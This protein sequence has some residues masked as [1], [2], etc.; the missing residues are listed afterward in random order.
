MLFFPRNIYHCVC[1]VAFLNVVEFAFYSF[2]IS[3]YLSF[4]YSILSSVLQVFCFQRVCKHTLFLQYWHYVAGYS[5]LRCEAGFLSCPTCRFHCHRGTTTQSMPWACRQCDVGKL[6]VRPRE[7]GHADS[8]L[9]AT[10][11]QPESCCFHHCGRP[12]L[13]SLGL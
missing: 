3:I 10:S 13:V 5:Q 12:T 4:F 9:W 7:G 1:P 2:I 8:T 11:S 6:V